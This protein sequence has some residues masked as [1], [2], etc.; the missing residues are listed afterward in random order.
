[1][2]ASPFGI[3]PAHIFMGAPKISLRERGFAHPPLVMVDHTMKERGAPNWGGEKPPPPNVEPVNPG[4][5]P[6]IFRGGASKK[7]RGEKRTPWPLGW[8][9]QKGP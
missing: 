2:G 6:K 8:I 4:N 5:F 1:V 7:L 3:Q 9:H